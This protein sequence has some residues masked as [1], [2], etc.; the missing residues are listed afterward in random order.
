MLVGLSPLLATTASAQNTLPKIFRDL[1]PGRSPAAVQGE[2]RD[3]TEAEGELKQ[4]LLQ[5]VAPGANNTS[6]APALPNLP[7]LRVQAKLIGPRGAM[8]LLSLGDKGVLQVKS[9]IS[10]GLAELPGVELKVN[11]I[12]HEGVE[13]EF[14]PLNRKLLLP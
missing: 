8:A 11:S 10:Y 2:S 9:G 12:S 13:L 5:P 3:P 4:L 14:Q 6:A 1:L 7:M